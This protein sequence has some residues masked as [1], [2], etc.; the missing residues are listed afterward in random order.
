MCFYLRPKPEALGRL[1]VD[2]V[3]PHRGGRW[4]EGEPLAPTEVIRVLPH[5][6]AAEAPQDQVMVW[7]MPG[8]PDGHVPKETV[9][10]PQDVI[11]P[12]PQLP[13]QPYHDP[14]PPV[15]TP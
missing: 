3:L 8:V 5:G 2:S 13:P 1:Y 10:R 4:S 12:G 9:I 7:V 14:R 6:G 15:T 11:R